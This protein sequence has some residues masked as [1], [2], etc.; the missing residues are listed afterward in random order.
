VRLREIY[1]SMLGPCWQ[2]FLARFNLFTLLIINS[3]Q[4]F[5]RITFVAAALTKRDVSQGDKDICKGLLLAGFC[6]TAVL[7]PSI[8]SHIRVKS[9]AKIGSVLA[10]L[11]ALSLYIMSTYAPEGDEF[12]H[13]AQVLSPITGISDCLLI[14]SVLTAF[15][16]TSTIKGR[17]W[18]YGL[19]LACIAVAFE[20]G[21]DHKGVF[22]SLGIIPT[23]KAS[24]YPEICIILMFASLFSLV[25]ISLLKFEKPELRRSRVVSGVEDPVSRWWRP[26]II[27]EVI[28]SALAV[29]VF[30]IALGYLKD[31]LVEELE[32]SYMW[33]TDR[34][35]RLSLMTIIGFVVACPPVGWCT[36]YSG[37]P[38]VMA[39][40]HFDLAGA[41][42]LL[43]LVVE[44]SQG[45]LNVVVFFSTIFGFCAAPSAVTSLISMQESL[46]Y[47]YGR[48]SGLA[49][50]S[51]Y[52]CC[53]LTGILFGIVVDSTWDQSF[54]ARAFECAGLEAILGVFTAVM[55]SPSFSNQ[56][57]QLEDSAMKKGE[58]RA[59]KTPYV[60]QND[61]VRI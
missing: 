7:S 46:E 8:G 27:P 14:I 26:L 23:T 29:I 11:I 61:F 5:E 18:N 38:S 13:G 4:G 50:S 33:S 58:H 21:I 40:G 2:N 25:L 60:L 45:D 36:N 54:Q 1:K 35:V 24:S 34:V 57:V 32:L 53:W 48:I 37:A 9:M 15:L 41:L 31:K 22:V 28:Q 56:A 51:F 52:V 12:L 44:G 49:T 10:L 17:S 16:N 59:I 19:F 39:I 42:L 3:I 6:L 47:D 20:L 43:G 55:I 30:S